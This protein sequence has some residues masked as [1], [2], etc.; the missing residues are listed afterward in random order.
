MPIFSWPSLKTPL[1][2]APLI[3]DFLLLEHTATAIILQEP[4]DL[5]CLHSY[6]KKRFP[7]VHLIDSPES[8]SS[9]YTSSQISTPIILLHPQIITPSLSI[10]PIFT[11]YTDSLFI[12]K[13][14][15]LSN[16]VNFLCYPE[17]FNSAHQLT[18]CKATSINKPAH[19]LPA[20]QSLEIKSSRHHSK[21]GQRVS[22]F[23]PSAPRVVYSTF[24]NS[25]KHFELLDNK[26]SN[27][28]NWLENS[29]CARRSAAFPQLP[30]FDL[31]DIDF[32]N[33]LKGIRA[34]YFYTYFAEG[35]LSMA[36]SMQDQSLIIICSWIALINSLLL[37]V[38]AGS[39]IH[40]EVLFSEFFI[41]RQS[42]LSHI[43]WSHVATETT[44]ASQISCNSPFSTFL[45]P[46]LDREFVK[47]CVEG[48]KNIAKDFQKG[49][50]RYHYFILSHFSTDILAAIREAFISEGCIAIDTLVHCYS[51][52]FVA[53]MIQIINEKG[54]KDL[55][56]HHLCF[57]D[58]E[59][60][61]I[62]PQV[63]FPEK[64]FSSIGK[65]KCRNL[66]LTFGDDLTAKEFLEKSSQEIFVGFDCNSSLKAF[67]DTQIH[68]IDH[69]INE[70]N[71]KYPLGLVCIFADLPH[72]RLLNINIKEGYT[73]L[74][75]QISQSSSVMSED[76][77]PVPEM[78]FGE[79]YYEAIMLLYTHSKL[80]LHNTLS[81]DPRL[82][83][84][85]TPVRLS[86]STTDPAQFGCRT[87][88]SKNG[89]VIS[90]H[91]S[92]ANKKADAERVGLTKILIDLSENEAIILGARLTQDLLNCLNKHSI[93]VNPQ[94]AIDSW[95]F[96]EIRDHWKFVQD[97]FNKT[98]SID[99][100]SCL[101]NGVDENLVP[102]IEDMVKELANTVE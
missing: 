96:K 86:T 60:Y 101:I 97:Y 48:L 39:P 7:G 71:N 6:L 40:P 17:N 36:N 82:T 22:F 53:V 33:E 77:M 73:D 56:F 37:S 12:A 34:T 92:Y 13:K 41:D 80:V 69:S 35:M 62:V 19:F 10:D 4:L 55:S 43:I 29:L 54:G 76:D 49:K 18:I 91:Y 30:L 5:H 51:R 98:N 59:N 14:F 26:L 68:M 42:E 100:P 45:W 25:A 27:V 64:V 84:S 47:Y 72:S 78:A 52:S 61:N 94:E 102:V 70:N 89:E 88:V 11:I 66:V 90:V 21:A 9:F 67:Y 15:E 20:T 75:E 63:Y 57:L 58:G 24:L 3:Y 50:G 79:T 81:K 44:I 28:L 99:V 95:I 1:K 16:R 87:T 31:I 83:V 85:Q 8:Y 38:A 46:Q 74:Y 2:H 93:K 32:V 23:F 65:R